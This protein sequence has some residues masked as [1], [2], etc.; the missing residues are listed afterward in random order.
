LRRIIDGWLVSI[1]A[2]EFNNLLPVLRRAFST[3]DRNERRRLLDELAKTPPM[4]V[5][6]AV[7][8]Q[9]S[10]SSAP[11]AEEAPGFA[12]AL[13]LLLTILGADAAAAPKETSP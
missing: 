6:S 2:E 3:F 1:G 10:P 5:P 7:E 4:A 11:L 13:P 8:Q 12:A 9:A